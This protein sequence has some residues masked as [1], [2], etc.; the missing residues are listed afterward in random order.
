MDQGLNVFDAAHQLVRRSA[1]Q[2]RQVG[3]AV[4]A[5]GGNVPVEHR[6]PRARQRQAQ[7]LLAQA[8]RLLGLLA[9]GDVLE[10]TEQ[11]HRLAVFEHRL[12]LGP[13]HAFVAIGGD[14]RE[15]EVVRRAV[16]DRV[17]DR[18]LNDRPC[19]R[20]IEVDAAEQLELGLGPE[21]VNAIDLFGPLD[22][23]RR[24]IELPAA[25]PGE[26]AHA[27]AQVGRA[28][29]GLAAGHALG[30]VHVRADDAHR[31]ARS[32][33]FDHHRA[34]ERPDPVA[35]LVAQA[36]FTLVEI[37]FAGEVPG[38]RRV[39]WRTVFAVHEAAPLG[40][41]IRHVLQ[42]VAK[43]RAFACV[44]REPAAGHVQVPQPE[45]TTAQREFQQLGTACA[46]GRRLGR[47]IAQ[48]FRLLL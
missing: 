38:H 48:V 17:V 26:R 39:Q 1:A 21:L 13:H 33:A 14:Q 36:H 3:A 29:F 20:R 25:D 45:I 6:Q 24:E 9:F 2:H 47:Q 34:A 10:G 19:L 42:G 15:F 8:Q 46:L 11:A 37:G 22:L 27:L 35:A 40:L 4:H 43:H 28:L 32:V 12:A 41:A 23:V 44:D 18:R 5:V 7:A 31:R 30:D 16:Q